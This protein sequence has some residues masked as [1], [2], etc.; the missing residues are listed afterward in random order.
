VSSITPGRKR[1]AVT[2]DG[3]EQ[4]LARLHSDPDA[5][6]ERFQALHS[7]LTS[8]FTYERCVDPEHWADATLDR[9]AKRVSDGAAVEDI[10]A[11]IYGIARFVAQE[12]RRQE[13]CTRDVLRAQPTAAPPA[14]ES[15]FQCLDACLASL[16]EE[17]RR[18]I[19]RYYAGDGKALIEQRRKLAEELGIS[20]ESLRTRALR[21]RKDLEYC[22]RYCR[23]ERAGLS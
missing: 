7:K 12:A 8:Y 16:S 18:L 15:T 13:Q 9:A 10:R 6:G 21:I 1:W 22:V 2:R 4:L 17:N 20:I 5:A 19:E 11:F 14:S 23:E 3:F